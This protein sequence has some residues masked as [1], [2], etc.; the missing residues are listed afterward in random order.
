MPLPV[1]RISPT[2]RPTGRRVVQRQSWRDLLF[3]HWRVPAALLAPHVGP[4]LTID[5]FEGEAWVGVVPF[6]M[7]G[8]RPVW[9]PPV[10]WLS[11]FHET[12][13]RTYVHRDGRDPGVW[14]FSL[15]A[16][17]AIAVW[18]AR[19]LWH[20]PY[21]HARMS[22][23]RRPDRSIAYESARFGATGTA[24]LR[25]RCEPGPG[26]GTAATGTLEEF[27]VERYLL[28]TR[29]RRG[30]LRCGQ[31]H[32]PRYPL[33][34]ARVLELEESLLSAAGL[35][36]GAEPPL[37]HYAAGVDVDVFGLLPA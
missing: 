14:F 13:V 37:A 22:L 7:R 4:G 12:N 27:L 28:Y 20:L 36:R 29:D 35:G 9:A 10:P 33:Q 31:V 32:H 18:L 6:T 23:D 26:V 1:D 30:R 2:L 17:N 15:D 8:V 16:A 5:T 19:T 24:S 21:H 25:V 11:N 34:S 3:L